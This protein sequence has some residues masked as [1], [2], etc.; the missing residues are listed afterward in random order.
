[1]RKKWKVQRMTI[2]LAPGLQKSHRAL[3]L[4]TRTLLGVLL[5][6]LLEARKL[7]LGTRALL[8]LS[9]T[10]QSLQRPTWRTRLP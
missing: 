2:S 3:L 4:G 6:V 8:R 10:A 5:A 1:M 7:Q 9:C